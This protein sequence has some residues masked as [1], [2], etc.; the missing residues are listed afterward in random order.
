MKNVFLLLSVGVL[1]AIFATGAHARNVYGYI[2][3]IGT[4]TGSVSSIKITDVTSGP[5]YG[6]VHYADGWYW[7]SFAPNGLRWYKNGLQTDHAYF[8]DVN[9]NGYGTRGTGFYLPAGWTD[10]RVKDINF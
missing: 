1:S 5:S 2:F 3:G 4:T 10:F 8:V 7:S 6:F 9:S